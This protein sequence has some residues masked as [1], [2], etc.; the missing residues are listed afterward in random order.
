MPDHPRPAALTTFRTRS[1]HRLG[2]SST[3][4]GINS[5]TNGLGNSFFGNQAGSHNMTGNNNSY[6]GWRA[7]Y[8]NDTGS[9]NSFFG[10]S[11]GSSN[12]A[13][14]NSFFGAS[15]GEGNTTGQ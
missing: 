10:N 4:V 1:T 12:K 6:F 14:S 7:G 8:F 5:G 2:G 15:A 11:A 9:S 3:S 13:S